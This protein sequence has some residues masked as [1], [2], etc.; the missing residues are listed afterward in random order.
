[1][2]W[3]CGVG[4]NIDTKRSANA[5]EETQSAMDKVPPEITSNSSA[6][7]E[8]YRA[9]SQPSGNLHRL[10]LYLRRGADICLATLV[11]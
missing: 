7:V 5:A 9:A 6:D 11:V 1:M 10:P 2:R 8:V 4:I 3:G